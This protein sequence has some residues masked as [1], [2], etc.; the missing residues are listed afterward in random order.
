MMGQASPKDKGA[1]A[2]GY[3]PIRDTVK[4]KRLKFFSAQG[5]DELV[6]ISLALAQEL[7]VVKARLAAVEEVAARHG[8][9]LAEEVEQLEWDANDQQ[10]LVEQRQA[11][12]DRVFHTLRE[13]AESLDAG[14]EAE[15]EPPLAPDEA[16]I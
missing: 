7:W 15:P 5:V 13:E 3:A 8:L 2:T 11:F 12:V 1:G 4:G 10:Q 6:A 9:P 16:S 14:S